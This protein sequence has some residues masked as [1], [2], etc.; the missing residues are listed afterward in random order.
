MHEN[1]YREK[2][3]NKADGK[4][5]LFPILTIWYYHQSLKPF[6]YNLTFFIPSLL[7]DTV[8][9]AFM[10]LHVFFCCCLLGYCNCDSRE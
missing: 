5:K 2:K 6:L 7:S 4:R 9:S 1:P 8:I 3:I 10:A